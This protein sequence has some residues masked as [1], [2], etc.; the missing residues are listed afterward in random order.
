MFQS[1]INKIIV[2]FVIIST[3]SCILSFTSY[4]HSKE[5]IHQ[6]DYV[7]QD[8]IKP[9]SYFSTLQSS[10]LDVTNLSLLYSPYETL[11]DESVQKEDLIL[12][13][14]EDVTNAIDSIYGNINSNEF[15]LLI[16]KLDSETK[17]RLIA[18]L[19]LFKPTVIEQTKSVKQAAIIERNAHVSALLYDQDSSQV[20]ASLNAL[21][22]NESL[23]SRDIQFLQFQTEAADKL[24]RRILLQSTLDEVW[25]VKSNLDR[26]IR[27]LDKKINYIAKKSPSIADG[28][29]TTLAPLNS[30]ISDD[31]GVLKQH[32]SKL[33]LQAIAFE[34]KVTLK[35][36][37]ETL[38]STLLDVQQVLLNQTQETINDTKESASTAAKIIFGLLTITLIISIFSSVTVTLKIRKSIASLTYALNEIS[39]G[40]LNGKKL[41]ESGD[42]FG[43]LGKTANLVRDQLKNIVGSLN[44]SSES[45]LVS[46]SSVTEQN[47][48]SVEI[49]HRQATDITTMSSSL[50]QM[51]KAIDE[52]AQL[53]NT[54]QETVERTR[55]NG[56]S[57]QQVTQA[58]LSSIQ[59]LEKKLI[60]CNSRIEV[61]LIESKNVQSVLSVIQSISE[62][63]NLLALNAAIESARA[64]EHGR[65]FSVVANEI[66]QLAEKTQSSTG[67]IQT[68]ISNLNNEIEAIVDQIRDCVDESNQSAEYAQEVGELYRIVIDDLHLV[69]DMSI[70]VSCSAEEQSIA[71]KDLLGRISSLNQGANE[72]ESLCLK[73]QGNCDKLQSIAS[74]NQEAVNKFTI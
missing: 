38:K 37:N 65:G 9:I 32:F 17:A 61:L 45:L 49:T 36:V 2:V 51:T 71:T 28:I 5:M 19:E 40:K 63:T 27:L 15:Q 18:A 47:N 41:Y 70:Q 68:I 74:S 44:T 48:F 10:L 30:A 67:N 34:K 46:T 62:Q 43:Q 53:A 73:T 24:V 33:E 4:N 60:R 50:E 22:P 3:L 8:V 12:V 39:V 54:T 55:E 69:N 20:S 16:S 57:C 29:A 66:R 14:E 23:R 35:E 11:R 56:E 42:E 6:L 31:N 72:I 1:V 7:E 64:G 21:K 13:S 26:H 58:S 25:I 59:V 52:V